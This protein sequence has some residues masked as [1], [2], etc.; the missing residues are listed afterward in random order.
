LD[1][2]QFAL[3]FSDEKAAAEVREDIAEGRKLGVGGTPSIFV[4]GIKVHRSSA[5]SFRDAI[6][7]ELKK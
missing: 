6:D 2:K 4:N 5:E 7:R 1:A 3:D